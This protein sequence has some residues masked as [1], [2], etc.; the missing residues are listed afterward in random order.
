MSVQVNDY[1]IHGIKLPY[2]SG[3]E[4][5]YEDYKDSA[6]EGIKE[7][8]GLCVI[9]DGMNGKYIFIGHVLAKSKDEERI[10]DEPICINKEDVD[11][12]ARGRIAYLIYKEFNLEISTTDVKLWLVTHYR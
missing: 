8:N 1:L 3:A 7:K 4:D 10:A 12:F 6:F 11:R 2:E 5:K 9:C